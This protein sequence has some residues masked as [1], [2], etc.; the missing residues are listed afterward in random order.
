MQQ[1]YY[2]DTCIWRDYLENR[3]DNFRPLGE[4]A[5]RL[6][7][8]IINDKGIIIYSDIVDEELSLDLTEKEKEEVLEIISPEFLLRTN[9]TTDQ[10]KRAYKLK[11]ELKTPTKDTM[12]AIIAKDNDAI[13][14]TRD[15]HFH[16]LQK[17]VNIKLPEDLI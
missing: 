4:W 11:K 12:H 15:K 17:I 5:I 10:W 14:V 13:L 1:K 2:L 3:S 7:N 6:I 9:A 8:K 16:E